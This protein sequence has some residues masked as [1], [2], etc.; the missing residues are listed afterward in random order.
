MNGP[1]GNIIQ[2][3]SIDILDL[4]SSAIGTGAMASFFR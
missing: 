4:N 1:W 3:R 2:G